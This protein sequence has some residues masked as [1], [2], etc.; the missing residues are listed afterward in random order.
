[1][2]VGIIFVLN[3][4]TGNAFAS[5]LKSFFDLKIRILIENF[6]IFCSNRRLIGCENGIGILTK[7]QTSLAAEET[8]VDGATE[9]LSALPTATSALELDVSTE[10]IHFSIHFHSPQFTV[11]QNH[12]PEMSHWSS[13]INEKSLFH[14]NKVS[15][16]HYFV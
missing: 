13:D 4:L 9:K 3:W 16:Y 10:I 7:L 15:L 14:L 8:W 11:H 6:D 2:F 5:A 1:M 12:P